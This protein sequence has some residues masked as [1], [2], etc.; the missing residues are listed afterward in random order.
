MTKEL[1]TFFLSWGK[2]HVIEY[3]IK[4]NENGTKLVTEK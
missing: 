2:E 4:K 3:E 1:W